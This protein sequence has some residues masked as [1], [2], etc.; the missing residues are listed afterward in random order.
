MDHTVVIR[1]NWLTRKPDPNAIY[2]TYL[3]GLIL[4]T[5]GFFSHWLSA[6]PEA[7][8]TKQEYWRAWTALFA[9]AD[10][11]HLLSNSMILLPLSVLLTGYFGYVFFPLTGVLMG[12][13][14][15]FLV[16]KTLPAQTS[17]LGISGV[18]NWMGAAWLTLFLLIDRRKSFRRRFAVAVFL[19]IM[20]FVPETFR[21]E[22]S[23]LSHFIGFALG[24]LSALL[25]YFINSAKIQ[26]AEIKEIIYDDND[27]DQQR[28][29]PAGGGYL[30]E[31][32]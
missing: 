24:I 20:L 23:Y 15:N 13:L 7:V 3:L 19:T 6:T 22:V 4:F 27:L 16:L 9:H 28:L 10:L 29:L 11:G 26:A 5:A 2:S 21:P 8:F 18:V 12:G 25:Y 1:E 17:L 32:R 31:P 30:V 14:T